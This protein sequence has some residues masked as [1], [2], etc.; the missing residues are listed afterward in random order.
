MGFF[1]T[2]DDGAGLSFV[3]AEEKAVLIANET[4]LPVHRVSKGSTKFGE[5]FLLITEIDGEERALS[6]GVG[7]VESRDRMFEAMMD[8][9][10]QDDAETPVVRLKKVGQSILVV[11]ADK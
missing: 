5:R 2:Y 3:G 9:L 11:D 10:T 1:D 4:P 7:S 8:Y 6:F